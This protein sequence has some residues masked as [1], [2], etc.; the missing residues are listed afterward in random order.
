LLIKVA[1]E[2]PGASNWWA[3]APPL[4]RDA[5]AHYTL[6]CPRAIERE[7]ER[8]AKARLPTESPADVRRTMNHAER[9]S[10][11]PARRGPVTEADLAL[12]DALPK[13][14]T[15]RYGHDRPTSAY[16]DALHELFPESREDYFHRVLLLLESRS[17]AERELGVEVLRRS[18]HWD[19]G[20]DYQ[21]FAGQR[22][23]KL[24][25]LRPILR[26]LSTLTEVEMRAEVLRLRGVTLDGPCG[27]NWLSA[28]RR[29]AVDLEPA[30]AANALEMIEEITGHYGCRH[31]ASLPAE[32]RG[33]ALTAFLQD[34]Q[35]LA[36]PDSG[37]LKD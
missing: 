35:T 7:L 23:A 14:E 36:A 3:A 28:L 17:L 16:R 21:A 18:L 26:K 27:K 34:R 10:G 2:L 20:F 11:R 4:F 9:M 37:P 15:S 24:N 8:R 13:T 29:A 6:L 1:C 30:I 12:L 5:V 32:Q 25:Q 33:A 19:F 22:A 31:L